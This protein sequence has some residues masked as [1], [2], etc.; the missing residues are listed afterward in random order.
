MDAEMVFANER[1]RL[2]V[3]GSVT[4]PGVVATPPHHVYSMFI[5]YVSE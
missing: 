2:I 1:P 4:I 5:I 3:S